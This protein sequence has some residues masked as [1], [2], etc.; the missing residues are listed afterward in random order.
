MVIAKYFSARTMGVFTEVE[1]Y[2]GMDALGCK[3][4][5]D[6]ADKIPKLKRELDN[7]R[8]FKEVYRFIFS[9]A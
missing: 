9:F 7:P 1:F 4:L 8:E 3:H 5:G 2:Q 6:L